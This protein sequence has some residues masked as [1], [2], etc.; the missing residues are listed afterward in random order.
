MPVGFAELTGLRR[1]QIP[2][3][4]AEQE[5]DLSF[6]IERIAGLPSAIQTDDKRLQQVL[7]NLLSNAFKFTEEGKVAYASR[8]SRPDGTRTII[9]PESSRLRAGIFGDRYRDRHL[10]G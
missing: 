8:K 10:A 7:K 5:L 9:G 3:S 6:E 1:S 2:S 4:R